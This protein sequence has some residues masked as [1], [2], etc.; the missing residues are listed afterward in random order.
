MRYLYVV[1]TLLCLPSLN[2]QTTV[3]GRVIDIK[4]NEPI[5][6]AS[7][8]FD[9]TGD[10][11]TTNFEGNFTL[12]TNSSSDTLVV[13][14]VGYV[15]QRIYVARGSNVTL[16]I[17]MVVKEQEFDRVKIVSKV[18]RALRVIEMAQ[19]NKH[20]YN[21]EQLNSFEC[22]SF[23]KI[24]IAVNN[25]SEEL[26]NKRLLKGVEG[27]FDTMSYL[28][29]DKTKQ[30]LPIFLS[31][32]LSNFYYNKNP[33]QNKEVIIASRVKGVGVEDG[34]FLSQLLG[35]TFQQYNF[36]D[37]IL[38]ILEKN[39]ISPISKSSFTYY[40]YK[41]VGSDYVGLTKIYQIE[42]TPKNPLDLVFTG[43]IWIEDSTFAL[44]RLS[45]SITNK[46][47]LNFVEKLKITQELEKTSTGAYVP[48]RSRILIDIAEISKK[49]AGMIALFSNSYEKL[50]VNQERSKK[51]FDYPITLMEDAT[52]KSDEFWDSVRH[53]ELTPDEKRALSKIDTLTNVKV[54]KN[55]V[56]FINI[57]F[58]GY[59]TIGKFDFGPYALLYGYNVLE[60][61]RVRLGAKTNFNFSKS[62]IFGA[63]G[64]YGF[65][66]Q[67]W[68]YK[69]QAEKIISRK[70]WTM[71]GA[72]YKNDI[73]QIGVT[74]DYYGASNLFTTVSVF[75]ASQLNRA[76]ES[77]LW[78]NSEFTKGWNAKIVFLHKEYKF[79]PVNKFNFAYFEN[80]NDTG[81]KN[82]DFTNA[83]ITLS[84]RWAPKEYYLQND[85]ERVRQSK[86]GGLALSI[87][88][89][90]GFKGFYGS[91][92]DYNRVTASIEKGL[93]FGYWGRTD[94]TLSATK[95]F[96]TLPYPLLEVH[97]GNQSFIYTTS[98]YNQ[99]DFFE[100]I[101]DQSLFFKMEHHFN[102]A[103]FNRIP[104]MKKLKWREFFE[105][106]AV[107][108]S[109]SQANMNLIPQYDENGV[110]VTPLKNNINREPYM[111]VAYGIENI[112]KVLQ[113]VAIHRLSP[114][115]GT[116]YRRFGLKVGMAVSF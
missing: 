52:Q 100:F 107:M 31:E 17:K 36:N 71:L 50:V 84:L 43:Y 103:I 108:G 34:S 44:T 24:Q 38:P 97:R 16:E 3:K 68:K 88:Y 45:L 99:M 20:L 105:G 37:N 101:T 41:L 5:T 1:I 110:P 65:T 30:V 96:E 19:K 57:I 22:E 4:T 111:E 87:N 62:Y 116:G 83:A 21:Y 53:E 2:A 76:K 58:N 70:H 42:V 78:F 18:N 40:N 39:F 26:K 112:F 115:Y 46:A 77:K 98:A 80:Q 47:N 10:Y 12:K 28:S 86:P 90:R 74:D 9:E 94:F 6:G 7:V 93:S 114:L 81:N 33:R 63:Y 113:V 82:S 55:Y 25:V 66:D 23:T 85:N 48:V 109:L 54:I 32:N 75:A 29:E 64:A 72:S 73:E 35:S 104:L 14:Y 79:E 61:H 8:Y 95:I 13:Y 102:G 56:E 59:K 49:S 106:R 69:V 91:K 89:T 15:K 67:R 51:F 92:F 27:I 60:G 11:T